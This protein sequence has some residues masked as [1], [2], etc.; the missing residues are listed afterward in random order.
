MMVT[1]S[2]SAGTPRA[3]MA[4][5]AR[6]ADVSVMTVSNVVNDRAARVSDETR[7]RVLAAI[8]AL[9]Y[10]VNVAARQLRQGRTGVIALAVP[11]FSAPYYGEL[12]TRLADRL[13]A[14]GLRLVVERTGG[15]LSD[16]LALLE[17]SRLSA[18]DGLIMS[19]TR[20]DAD[21]L[22]EAHATRPVVALGERGMSAGVDHVAMDNVGGARLAT[23]HLLA[24]GARRIAVVGGSLKDG[25]S[26]SASRT[27]GHV[28]ALAAA[29]LAPEPSLVIEGGVD[30]A[31]GYAAV[32]RLA[33][34]GVGFDAVLA[35]TDT[36]ALGALAGL[37]QR[38]LSVP[39]D[40]QVVGWDNTE[41]GAYGVPT[42]T[43]VDPDNERLAAEAVRLLLARL[44]GAASPAEQ[45]VPTASL[46]VRGSTRSGA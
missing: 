16:E 32:T 41:S 5:V 20:A 46:A 6:A 39:G 11:D 7:A 15:A 23:E 38:G 13:A 24:R 1:M 22:A 25:E 44:D 34:A 37:S 43:S 17:R 30:L 35:L 45:V 26:M 18:Y 9:G 3:T 10:Q 8:D 33:D 29:G 21:D 12:A 40:V 36:A 4:D 14:S 2:A 31:A 42:L 27:R 19:L 28:E